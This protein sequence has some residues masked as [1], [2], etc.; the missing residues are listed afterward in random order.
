[1][2]LV[3]LVL[4]K[5]TVG[6]IFSLVLFGIVFDYYFQYPTRKFPSSTEFRELKYVQ[7]FKF[8]NS[9]FIFGT[10]MGREVACLEWAEIRQDRKWLVLNA[11]DGY[12]KNE[13]KNAD[14]FGMSLNMVET[15]DS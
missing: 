3:G 12:P 11:W 7:H 1:M 10:E 9:H 15:L 14:P 2:I 6:E 8:Q 13:T 5:N 4:K